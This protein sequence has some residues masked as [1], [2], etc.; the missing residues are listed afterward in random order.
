MNQRLFVKFVPWNE[1]TLSNLINKT[2]R[3]STVFDFNEF[4][5]FRCFSTLEV[6]K[7][8]GFDPIHHEV[9]N[10]LKKTAG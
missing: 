3:F 5:E 9:M 2:I 6:N 10:I 4:N 7:K 1:R 8:K